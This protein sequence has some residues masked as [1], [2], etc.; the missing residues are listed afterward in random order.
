ME[1]SRVKLRLDLDPSTQPI[2]GRVDGEQGPPVDFV[3]WMGLMGA[4]DRLLA[5]GDQSKE[6]ESDD[7]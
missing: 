7:A 6:D 1:G 3:G 4:L 2:T 5:H